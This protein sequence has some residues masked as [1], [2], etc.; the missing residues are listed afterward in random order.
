MFCS[1]KLAPPVPY[2]TSP[3][4]SPPNEHQEN[5]AIDG[6][7]LYNIEQNQNKGFTEDDLEDNKQI[8]HNGLN[9]YSPF[10]Q[11]EE[12]EL[13]KQMQGKMQHAYFNKL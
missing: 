5:L 7:E 10:L 12:G 13:D 2:T 11:N 8:Y 4:I 3:P 6:N 9:S 1:E